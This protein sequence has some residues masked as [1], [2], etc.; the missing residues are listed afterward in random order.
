D[1]GFAPHRRIAASAGF[2]AVQSTP[3]FGRNGAPLGMLSTHFRRPHRPTLRELNLTDLYARQAAEMIERKQGEEAL[4]ESQARLQAVLDHSPA[5][6]FLKDLD[7][8]YLLSNRQFEKIA[9]VPC[10]AVVGKTDG[11][12]FS[13][14]QAEA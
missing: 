9:R 14:E 13:P 1:P 5:M 2:R 8:R 10:E 4:R 12:L 7:G 3:L 11:E 6:I